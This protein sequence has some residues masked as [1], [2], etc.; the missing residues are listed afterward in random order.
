MEKS[1]YAVGIDLGRTFVKY[2]LVRKDVVAAT[3]G[4]NAGCMGTA[5]LVFN[6]KPINTN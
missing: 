6:K 5:S 3:L 2:A 1:R 4:N